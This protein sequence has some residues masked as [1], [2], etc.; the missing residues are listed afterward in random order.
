MGAALASVSSAREGGSAA[1]VGPPPLL[2]LSAITKTWRGQASPVLSGVDLQLE[3]GV[4]AAI[5]GIN[6]AG[7]T[8]L[9]R[10]TGG[11]ITP[12]RGEVRAGGLSPERDRADFQRR[13][14][15]LS[16]GNSGLYARL[17]AEHHL[18]FWG[19]LALLPGREL[20]PAIR[21]AGAMFGLEPLLGRRVDR[22]SMG[23]RQRLRLAL[24]FLHQPSLVLL[25][26]PTTSLDASG[27][28]LVQVALDA[29]KARGGAAL[30]C[31]PTGWEQVL[32]LDRTYVLAGGALELAR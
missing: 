10:I 29:L 15:F 23:Q 18:E 5:S 31:V 14:G 28:A 9:L 19:R 21:D 24:A 22:L 7:K 26:E 4:T 8:T 6:G 17:K 3:P 2:L 16:A 1:T 13:I 25:D 27:I 12:D 30:V 32:A 20:E 11:L